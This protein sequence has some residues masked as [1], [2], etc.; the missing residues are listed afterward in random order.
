VGKLGMTKT[1]VTCFSNTINQ[2][3]NPS[4]NIM[5]RYLPPYILKEFWY[6]GGPS[7][8]FFILHHYWTNLFLSGVHVCVNGADAITSASAPF[9]MN[10]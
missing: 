5:L 2:S 6:N 10:S 4:T 9:T 8:D 7:Q 1:T 3:I